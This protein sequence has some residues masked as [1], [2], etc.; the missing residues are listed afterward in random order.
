LFGQSLNI[1]PFV[2]CRYDGERSSFINKSRT[3]ANTV[4][5]LRQRI[6]HGPEQDRD[7]AARPDLQIA[8]WSV[9]IKQ[10]SRKRALR[11]R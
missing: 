8:Y 2:V 3:N 11:H 6:Q 9:S 7:R 10:T 1:F 5:F 4:I